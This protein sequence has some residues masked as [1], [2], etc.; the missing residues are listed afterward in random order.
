MRLSAR[1]RSATTRAG[2][3]AAFAPP[4]HDPRFLAL[5]RLSWRNPPRPL[6]MASASTLKLAL[7]LRHHRQPLYSSLAPGA[8][9]ED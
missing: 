3:R 9:F 4:A 1:R 6:S 7:F 5:P 2:P 8:V